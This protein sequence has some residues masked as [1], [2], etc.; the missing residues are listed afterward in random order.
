MEAKGRTLT[1][2]ALKFDPHS[3]VSKPHFAEYKIEETDSMTIFIAL[4]L[5]RENQDPDLKL[6]TLSAALGFAV[7]AQ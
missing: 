5:I 7:A 6:L 3:A 2:R 4:N 1:I